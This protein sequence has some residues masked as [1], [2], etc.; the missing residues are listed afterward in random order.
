MQTLT[1]SNLTHMAGGFLL[2][3]SW[4]TFANWGHALPA[5]LVAG[6]TQGILTACITLGLK[7]LVEGL[8]A[9]PP[10]HAGVVI[11]PLVACITSVTLLYTVHRLAGTPKVWATL[12]V[13]STVASL[14]AALYTWRLRRTP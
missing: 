4:A 7:R 12:A 3:G 11:P 14:Y 5:P 1:H 9:R 10:G 8:S 13:P 2:M 6:L